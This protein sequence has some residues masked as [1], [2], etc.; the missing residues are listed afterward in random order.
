MKKVIATTCVFIAAAGGWLWLSEPTTD[1]VQ[2]RSHEI[3]TASV[4]DQPE[5]SDNPQQANETAPQSSVD[6]NEVLKM[7]ITHQ[8]FR[9]ELHDFFAH[10]D[11]AK[12]LSKVAGLQQKLEELASQKLVTPF[13]ELMIR[14]G[15]LKYTT[16]EAT[17]ESESA[18]LIAEYKSMIEAEKS[19]ASPDPKHMTYKEREHQIMKEVL[20]MEEYPDGLSRDDYL[21]QRLDQVRSEVYSLA[22]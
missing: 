7:M 21:K 10:E 17:F 6:N 1:Q 19:T 3:V 2:T 14:L 18:R 16:D 11:V 12:D 5:P 20:S 8:T 22:E 4:S 13:E 9:Q 15:L